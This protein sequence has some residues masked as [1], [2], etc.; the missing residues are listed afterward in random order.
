MAPVNTPS[1]HRARATSSAAITASSATPDKGAVERKKRNKIKAAWPELPCSVRTGPRAL[2]LSRKQRKQMN[3]SSCP[4]E[5][6]FALRDF[7]LTT[8]QAEKLLDI[9]DAAVLHREYRGISV[10]E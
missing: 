4:I 3:D 10:R 9:R 2:P 1:S 7:R 8:L 6:R 5:A